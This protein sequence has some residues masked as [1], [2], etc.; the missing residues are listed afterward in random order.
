METNKEKIKILV[1]NKVKLH[2]PYL[3]ILDLKTYKPA[4]INCASTGDFT[5]DE[6]ILFALQIMK[7]AKKCRQLNKQVAAGTYNVN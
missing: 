5:P 3:N 1:R 6:A 7:Q 2:L 4:T